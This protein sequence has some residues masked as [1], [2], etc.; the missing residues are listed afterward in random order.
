MD[1]QELTPEDDPLLPAQPV[2]LP[3]APDSS[4]LAT[5]QD[6]D[7]GQAA[8][9]GHDAQPPAPVLLPPPERQESAIQSAEPIAVQY[10]GFVPMPPPSL[11][12]LPDQP[13]NVP[14][15]LE[16]RSATQRPTAVSEGETDEAVR[17]EMQLLAP[18]IENFGKSLEGWHQEMLAM[19][20]RQSR[21]M[22]S[23]QGM[24]MVYRAMLEDVRARL[25]ELERW[26][27]NWNGTSNLPSGF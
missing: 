2:E 17:L 13:S 18:A 19:F 26:A 8:H 7:A 1:D 21:V 16:T 27:A 24:L 10:S 9:Q 22:A 11:P 5:G 4:A 20:E 25:L 23:Q 6:Q 15:A 3:P 12:P 14:A